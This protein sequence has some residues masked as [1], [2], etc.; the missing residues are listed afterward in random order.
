MRLYKNNKHE[1]YQGLTRKC[2]Y[3]SDRFK[4]NHGLERYCR[5]KNGIPNFCKS[6]QKK[7]YDENK[8]SKMVIALQKANM[9]LQNQKDPLGQNIKNLNDILGPSNEKIVTSDLLDSVG[10]DISWYSYRMPSSDLHDL[11]VV[12]N[13]TI[14]WISQNESISI[15]KIKRK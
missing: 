3:C 14:E 6:E 5:E 8:L 7:L 1:P 13:F 12:G 15:F 4:V 9:E 2:D 11:L 10:Y